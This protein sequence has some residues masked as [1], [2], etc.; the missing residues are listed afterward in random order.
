[1]DQQ[2]VD[3]NSKLDR[4]IA[5]VQENLVTKHELEDLRAELPTRADIGNLQISVDGIA[6]HYKDT[7]EELKITAARTVRLEEWIIKTAERLGLDYKP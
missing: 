4:L 6:R 1:M 5:F 2:L 3:L 7:Q